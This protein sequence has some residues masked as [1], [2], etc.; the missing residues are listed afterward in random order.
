M[1]KTCL[2][3]QLLSFSLFLF[4]NSISRNNTTSYL[5]F[6]HHIHYSISSEKDSLDEINKIYSLAMPPHP[7]PKAAV[8][9]PSPFLDTSGR[10]LSRR[11]YNHDYG[12]SSSTTYTRSNVPVVAWVCIIAAVLILTV[13]I[14][15][16]YTH[17]KKSQMQARQA[18]RPWSAPKPLRKSLSLDALGQSPAYGAAG[19]PQPLEPAHLGTGKVGFKGVGEAVD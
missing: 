18:A 14:F 9:A 4:Q 8:F 13:L 17:D 10:A 11:Q 2:L 3:S 19:A 12:S 15:A 6:P 7:L 16:T 5:K 1:Y